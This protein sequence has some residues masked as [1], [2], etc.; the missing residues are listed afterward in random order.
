[1]K[2]LISL[3]FA[4]YTLAISSVSHAQAKKRFTGKPIEAGLTFGASNYMGDLSPNIAL[5][6]S[7]LMGGLICRFNYSDFFTLRGN[8]LFGQ[9]SGN[10]KNYSDDPFR[11][12]RNLN[13][14]SNIVEFSAI[15]ELNIFGYEETTRGLPSSPFLLFGLGLYKFNPKSQFKYL[16]GRNDASGVAIHNAQLKV[17]DNQWIELQTLSTEAQETTKYNERRRYPLT[18][19]SIPIGVGFKKQFNDFWAWGIEL[20]MRKTFTDYIDDISIDYVDDQIVAGAN[21][22]LAGAMKDRGPEIND[23]STGLP[24]EKFFNGDPRGSMKGNDWYMF[25]NFTITRK[26]IGGKAV[27]F[28]F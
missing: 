4:I 6:E 20:G 22:Y 13:F 27:C 1:M 9:I 5:G 16:E 26:I 7:H 23:P 8:A 24:Y 15:G 21:G 11:N 3:F 10:D 25:L 19:I 2:I 14:K 17:F 12:R 28:Q 18:Q